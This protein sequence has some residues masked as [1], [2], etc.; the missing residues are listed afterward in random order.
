MTMAD[1]KV[2]VLLSYASESRKLEIDDLGDQS[3]NSYK[4]HSFHP[5][6]KHNHLSPTYAQRRTGQ[7][8]RVSPFTAARAV[9]GQYLTAVIEKDHTGTLAHTV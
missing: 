7:L 3:R 2:V 4:R 5:F 9:F 6:Q 8:H 1:N